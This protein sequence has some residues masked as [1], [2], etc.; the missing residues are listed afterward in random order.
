MTRDLPSRPTAPLHEAGTDPESQLAL[1]RQA[2]DALGSQAALA[3]QLRFTVRHAG[4]LYSGASPL[5]DGI[6]VVTARALIAHAD[7]CRRLERAL[8]PAFAGNLMLEQ[9]AGA[10]RRGRHWR[11][12]SRSEEPDPP[13]LEFGA[14][15]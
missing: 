6:L 1:F 14:T 3:R 15:L 2:V 10:T 5:H 13:L 4:R 8:S 11:G 12:R 9:R 7:L